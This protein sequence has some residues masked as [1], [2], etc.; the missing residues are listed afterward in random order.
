MTRT[1]STCSGTST[2][3]SAKSFVV[4]DH[5][6]ARTRYALFETIRQFAEDRLAEHGGLED[7]RPPRRCSGREAATRWEDWDGPGW[8]AVDWV[9]T[10]LGNLRTAYR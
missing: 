6:S 5:S 8:R 4:A 10:E 7:T 1:T 9:E 2:R 3:S